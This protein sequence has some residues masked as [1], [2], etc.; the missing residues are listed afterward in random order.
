[1]VASR[2]LYLPPWS[3]FPGLRALPPAPVYLEVHGITI[4]S[5]FDFEGQPFRV[6]RGSLVDVDK[7]SGHSDVEQVDLGVE[8]LPSW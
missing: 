6:L 5:S 7:N 2:L 3:R 4:R 8:F 1:M